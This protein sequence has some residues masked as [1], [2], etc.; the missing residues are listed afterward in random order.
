ML[1]EIRVNLESMVRVGD[2]DELPL[3]NSQQIILTHRATHFLGSDGN[4]FTL[5]KHGDSAAIKTRADPGQ[6]AHAL[7]AQSALRSHPGANFGEDAFLPPSFFRA[8]SPT[9]RK[10]LSKKSISDACPPMIR[11]KR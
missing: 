5:Q 1:R 6:L 11:S 10:A 9:L 8:F 7:D 4:P 3:P 2:N